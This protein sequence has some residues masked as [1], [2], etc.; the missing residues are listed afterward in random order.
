[1]DNTN[2][3]KEG[4]QFVVF[5]TPIRLHSQLLAIKKMFNMG[6]EVMELLENIRF[7]FE[8]IYPY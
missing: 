6:L 7:M 3:I 8:Q 1:M 4:A 2:T 5:T